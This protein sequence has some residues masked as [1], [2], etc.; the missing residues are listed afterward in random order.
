M[1]ILSN[2]RTNPNSYFI[3]QNINTKTLKAEV[4]SGLL[5]RGAAV[6]FNGSSVYLS[7]PPAI[8]NS[9]QS[10]KEQNG[11]LKMTAAAAV[12]K[13]GFVQKQP[14]SPTARKTFY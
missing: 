12:D 2:R 8:N 1:S 3:N 5:G 11:T 9:G 14:N 4:N 10:P 13:S 7:T 6:I